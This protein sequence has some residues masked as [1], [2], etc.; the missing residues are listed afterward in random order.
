MQDTVVTQSCSYVVNVIIALLF[1][2]L[3]LLTDNYLI[4]LK[5]F[6]YCV[7]IKKNLRLIGKATERERE[8]ENVRC[9]TNERKLLVFDEN[10][11][12]YFSSSVIEF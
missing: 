1:Y 12:R 7:F 9:H 5:I 11:V 10:T 3:H 6:V 4:I 2:N 8:R